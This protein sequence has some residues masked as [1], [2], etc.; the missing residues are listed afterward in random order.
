LIPVDSQRQ[1]EPVI[2]AENPA[3]VVALAAPIGN[4]EVGIHSPRISQELLDSMNAEQTRPE[5]K[6]ALEDLGGLSALVALLGVDMQQGLSHDQVLRM[7]TCF[8]DNVFPESPMDSF[9][10][11]LLEALTDPTLIILICAATVSLVIGIVTEPQHGW[12]EGCAIFVAVVLVSTIAAGNDYSKQL[13]F[14][15]LENSSAKDERTSVLRDNTIERINPS[16]VVVGDIIVLQV[17]SLTFSDCCTNLSM[18]LTTFLSLPLYISIDRG[19]DSSRQHIDRSQC[20]QDQRVL[21]NRR[22]K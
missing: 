10:T 19:H 5:N 12:I 21:A 14:R 16:D 17:G 15:A 9:L 22:T 20:G 6:K 1:I 11:L 13:Q 3:T 7:R 2:L 18:I 8:G 4:S